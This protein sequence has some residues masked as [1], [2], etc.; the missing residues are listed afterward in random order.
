MKRITQ[1]VQSMFDSFLAE[2]ADPF[3]STL[4]TLKTSSHTFSLVP[5]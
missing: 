1:M 2:C 3:K 5:F 4:R